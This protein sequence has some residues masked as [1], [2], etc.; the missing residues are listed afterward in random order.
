MFNLIAETTS[1]VK[2]AA[3]VGLS[4]ARSQ[5]TDGQSEAGQSQGPQTHQEEQPD[6]TDVESVAQVQPQTAPPKKSKK[7]TIAKPTARKI[8]TP[9]NPVDIGKEEARTPQVEQGR[10]DL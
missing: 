2:Q 8:A 10:H 3:G 1:A 6:R 5:G 4:T 9:D 7:V